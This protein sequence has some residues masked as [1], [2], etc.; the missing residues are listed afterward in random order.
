MR[1]S[2]TSN[3][4]VT[5]GDVIG[6]GTLYW[7]PKLSGGTGVVTG[8]NGTALA[9]KTIQQ[10]SIAVSISAGQAKNVYYDYDGDTLAFGAAWTNLTT[11][12][13][14]LADEQGAVVLSS[15]HTKLLIGAVCGTG[16]NTLEDSEGG[17]TSQVG[18]KRF[19]WNAYNQVK[20]SMKVIEGTNNWSYTTNTWRQANGASGNKVEWFTGDAVAVI[21]AVARSSVFVALTTN[22]AT[23]GVGIDSITA[24]TGF[25][26]ANYIQRSDNGIESVSGYGPIN[27]AYTGTP[28]LGYHYAAWLEKG[29]SA[30]SMIFVGDNGTDEQ[31]TGLD[32]MGDF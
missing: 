5:S 26:Q 7:T 24:P 14:T 16:T 22:I 3:T 4:Y 29:N 1:L 23:A 9:Q 27:G 19:V 32:A 31:Q 18:G 17:V 21:T 13:E 25:R 8:Y 20:R 2:L 10:K 12:S 28:G 6:A 15:D 30:T 11:P